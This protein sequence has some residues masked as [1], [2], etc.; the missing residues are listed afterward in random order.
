MK[1]CLF[2]LLSLVTLAG[3]DFGNAS[4]ESELVSQTQNVKIAPRARDQS[5]CCQKEN[6]NGSYTYGYICIEPD[7][8]IS[9]DIVCAEKGYDMAASKRSKCDQSADPCD[10]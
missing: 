1:N 5:T 8:I 9:Q 10:V 6:D 2:A 3:C 7:D 4:E